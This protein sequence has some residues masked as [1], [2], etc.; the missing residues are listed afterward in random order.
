MRTTHEHRRIDINSPAS[1]PNML[2]IIFW[3][4]VKDL[5][6][7]EKITQTNNIFAKFH[8]GRNYLNNLTPA[9]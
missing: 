3:L 2:K 4:P 7:E 9:Y 5:S 1:Y 8:S 6:A